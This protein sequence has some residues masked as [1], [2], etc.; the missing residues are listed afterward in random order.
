MFGKAIL[1]P[2]NIC[3]YFESK[4]FRRN[5]RIED[6]S[7]AYFSYRVDDQA[8]ETFSVFENQTVVPSNGIKDLT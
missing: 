7:I 8:A 6:D 2:Y 1:W 5:N 3:N 4:I